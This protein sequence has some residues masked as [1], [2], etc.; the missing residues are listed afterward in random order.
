MQKSSAKKINVVV[1]PSMNSKEDIHID[2]QVPMENIQVI[3]NGIDCNIFCPLPHILSKKNRLITT[4]SADVPLKGLDFSLEAI[5]RL[6]L[7]YPDIHLM[8]IGSPR[9]EGH[10][11]RLLKKLELENHV[12][13]RTNLTKEEITQEY[14]Q[15]KA[16]IVS[17]LYEGFGFP[18][19]EAMACATPLVATNVASI[20][21]ITGSFAQLIKAEN[22]DEI[23]KG[24]KNIFQNPQKY[25]IQAEL[26]REHIIENFNWINIG[27]AYEKLLYQTIDEFK[28]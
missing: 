19:G 25:K 17:S 28:C 22:A 15:S 23:Y 6:K 21:E 4:A 3:P 14:A 9:K 8:V 24:I 26:G 20:P 18:V 2:F 1:T 5:A 27:R 13:F 10:T 12:S 16:A 7:E 11:E